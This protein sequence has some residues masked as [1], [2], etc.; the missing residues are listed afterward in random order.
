MATKTIALPPPFAGQSDKQPVAALPY[1]NSEICE[2]FN[3]DDSIPSLR[4]GEKVFLTDNANLS[5]ALAVYGAQTSGAYLIRVCE[6][7]ANVYFQDISSGVVVVG[8]TVPLA[9]TVGVVATL[10]FN[11]YLFFCGDGELLSSHTGPQFF[12]GTAWGLATYTWPANFSP[13]GGAVFNHRAYFIGYKASA[14]SAQYAYTEIDAITGTTHLVDLSTVQSLNGSLI[15]IR[16]VTYFRYYQ[17]KNVL[18][19]LF[20]SGEIL[21]YDGSYPD[22]SDW[23]QS[24]QYI[25]PRPLSYDCF[26]ECRD[27]TYI[28][29]ESG[30]ISLRDLFT[31]GTVQGAEGVLQNSISFTI[32]SRWKQIIAATGTTFSNYGVQGAF[33]KTKDRLVVSFPYYVDRNDGSLDFT[34]GMRLIYSFISN[35]WTEH[36]YKTPATT[37]AIRLTFYQKNMYYLNSGTTKNGVMKMEGATNYADERIGSAAAGYDFHLR[38][39]PLPTSK[40]GIS[41][42]TGAEVIMTTDIYSSVNFKF[43]GDIGAQTTAAQQTSGNGAFSTKCMVNA[44]LAQATYVQLDISGTTTTGSTIG[45]D[46]DGLNVWYDAGAEA[47]R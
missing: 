24:G 8:L 13:F 26:I 7:G 9:N 29:T 28:I 1:P 36:A 11:K 20:D 45:L 43:I 18:A 41:Q 31:K 19:F 47:S 25:I 46:I 35:A 33:D 27:D 38:P 21:I 34:R 40:T 10:Y 17:Q 23:S 39:A 6:D 32:S 37:L 2:N 42:I 44:G 4:H 22:G 12:N 3:L 14:V 16:S 15:G 30:L 5:L